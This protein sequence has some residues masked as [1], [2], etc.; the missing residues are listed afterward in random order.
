MG[1]AVSRSR[2]V[3][4]CG[5]RDFRDRDNVYRVLDAERDTDGVSV[6]VHGGCR[7]GADALAHQWATGRR[8]SVRVFPADWGAHGRAAGPI[9]N[10]KMLR[11]TTPH[12]L[13]AFP[14]GRGTA[15]CVNA[16]RRLHIPVLE[17]P[18]TPT[19]AAKAGAG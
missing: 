10:R 12:L 7:S 4:V 15:D 13:I 18:A 8:V 14:G 17:I 6:I 16:A 11:E 2:I 3:A 1:A 5:G 19:T 9:R